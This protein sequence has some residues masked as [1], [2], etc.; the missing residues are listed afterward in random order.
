MTN[1]AERLLADNRELAYDII[2]ET[3]KL[4]DQSNSYLL[5]MPTLL[6]MRPCRR[7]PQRLP[8]RSTSF[9]H[10]DIKRFHGPL[11]S[12]CESTH[13]YRDAGAKLPSD[14]EG[15][16]GLSDAT[17]QGTV[18]KPGQVDCRQLTVRDRWMPLTNRKRVVN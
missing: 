11:C 12:R 17:E 7:I 9:S 4:Q 3:K 14:T 16:M 15:D 10:N 8:I 2:T 6:R 18:Q 1:T 5:L 13:L